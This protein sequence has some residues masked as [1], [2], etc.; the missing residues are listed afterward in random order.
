MTVTELLVF[1]VLWVMLPTALAGIAHMLVVRQQWVEFL[2][3]PIWL[4][5]LGPNKTWR[6]VVAMMLF[7]AL[8]VCGFELVVQPVLPVSQI[9]WGLGLGL[10][11]V[12]AELPNSFVKRRMGIAAGTQSAQRPWLS[13][14]VDKM[15][16]AL[17]GSVVLALWIPGHEDQFGLSEP[18]SAWTVA[19][20]TLAVN[21]GIHA[22]LSW[23]LVVFKL[24][25]RF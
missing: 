18:Q 3:Q 8:A 16:S 5:G 15:D 7:S 24:K 20:A 14:A 1:N 12:L 9:L 19:V 6:G 4:E 10:L 25:A 22:V 2:A 17:L 21:S 13:A 23:I 11:Y